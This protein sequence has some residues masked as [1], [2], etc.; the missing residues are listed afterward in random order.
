ME[1]QLHTYRHNLLE[2]RQSLHHELLDLIQHLT[3]TLFSRK[4]LSFQ[5]CCLA[6][7]Q[8]TVL[9]FPTAIRLLQRENTRKQQHRQNLAKNCDK[10]Y[11]W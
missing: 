9:R 6:G 7:W 8:D 4:G 3:N 1:Y 2:I 11:L 10:T 5:G